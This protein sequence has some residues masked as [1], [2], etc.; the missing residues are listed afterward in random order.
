MI[1]IKLPLGEL[2][3]PAFA[4]PAGTTPD[5]HLRRMAETGVRAKY[6]EI[7][8]ELRERLD[9]E[10]SVIGK[11]GYSGYILIVQDFIRY[12][13]ENGILTAV[14]GSAGGSLV[15]LRHRP[16]RH[17]S[18]PLRADLRPLPESRSATPCRTSTSTSWTT[19]A[20]R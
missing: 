20:T 13:R 15:K 2:Q 18:D 5:E 12:A 7:A 1:D 6:G 4:V 3:L 14:R 8:A 10:L 19:A 17:R 16:H 9:K 11:L